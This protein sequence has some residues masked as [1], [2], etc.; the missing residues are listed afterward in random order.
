MCNKKVEMAI[1]ESKHL[2]SAVTNIK[3]VP[4]WEECVNIPSD[5][6]EK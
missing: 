5:Q 4:R 6:D 3:F 2:I 1:C